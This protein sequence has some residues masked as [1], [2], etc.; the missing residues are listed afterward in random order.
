MDE[1][2]SGLTITHFRN[3]ESFHRLLLDDPN[4]ELNITG[5]EDKVPMKLS[6]SFVLDAI[7]EE[8]KT[9]FNEDGD[10]VD[11]ESFDTPRK[12][13]VIHSKYESPVLNFKNSSQTLPANG[14]NSAAK[15][16]WHQYGAIPN[17]S[18]AGVFSEITDIPSRERTNSLLTA[19]LAD[20]LGID[21]E[22]KAIG[23][24]ATATDL[25]EGLVILPYYVDNTKDQP[26]R[27]FELTSDAVRKTLKKANR[28]SVSSADD[29]L[30]RQARLM[31]EYVFPPFLDWVTFSPSDLTEA[32]IQSNVRKPV[33]YVFEFSR[34]LSQ[35]DLANIWQGVL[36]DAGLTAVEQEAVIDLD[37]DFASLT[38]EDGTPVDVINANIQ[39]LL[40][41]GKEPVFEDDVKALNELDF[42]DLKFFVF[43]VKKRGE[44]QYSRI[45]KA[46]EDDNLQFDFKPFGVQTELPFFDD[47]GKKRLAYSYNYPYDFCSLIELAKVDSQIELSEKIATIAPTTPDEPPAFVN[48]TVEEDTEQAGAQRAAVDAGTL[49]NNAAL[50]ALINLTD[51]GSE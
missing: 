41:S 8:K 10:I 35:Q 29:Q 22:K 12:K 48:Q 24:L 45:T 30:V 17:Y 18:D 25:K 38:A 4:Y 20:A 34:T 7:V 49:S 14:P 5:S 21:K 50:Q 28:K 31:K 3:D 37:T 39:S 40:A 13:L 9:K 15:G 6:S 19:S 44:F 51:G 27:F 36:P 33:M 16:M 26:I 32:N 11:F 1:I 47:F 46:V 43:K 42:D 2:I 23:R